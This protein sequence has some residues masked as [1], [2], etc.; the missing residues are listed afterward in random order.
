MQDA[1]YAVP[2]LSRAMIRAEAARIRNVFRITGPWVDVV[3]LLEVWL[4]RVWPEF[5]LEIVDVGQLGTLHAV[6]VPERAHMQVREDVYNGACRGVGRDRFTLAH[7]LGHIVLHSDV[8][9]ARL[10]PGQS[11]PSFRSSEW[12]ANSFAG[13]VLISAEHLTGCAGP[14]D[15][16]TRFG[17]SVEA[18][19]VQW[20]VFDQEGLT[21]N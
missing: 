20:T 18:A 14:Q 16:A 4:P 15:L 13:E 10:E 8:E 12:Q 19:R 1:G 21:P 3:R 7:E 11:V 9:Y 2:P 5:Y 6:T 17:V